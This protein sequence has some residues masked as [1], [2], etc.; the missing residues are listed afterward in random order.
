[1][2]N[3]KKTLMMISLSLFSIALISIG[4]YALWNTG[5]DLLTGFNT[6]QSGQVKMS[7]TETN[8]INMNNA[9][10]MQDS[11]GKNLDSYFE[12][13]ISTYIKTRA[14]DNAKRKLKY[15]IMFENT[16]A[17]I[18]GKEIS[19]DVLSDEN[20]GY[21]N[22]INTFFPIRVYLT[23]VLDNG[24]EVAVVEPKNI[25]TPD[26]EFL[27]VTQE[28]VFSNN[29][30]QVDTKYRLRT[31]IDYDFNI[32]DTKTI[33]GNMESRTFKINVNTDDLKIEEPE[34]VPIIGVMTGNSGI[35]KITHEIDDTLQVDS[36]FATEYRYSGKTANNYVT[37]N[38]ELWRII[39][40]IP[41]DDGT[42]KVENRL[43][44]IKS[45]SIGNYYW[46]NCNADSN[47]M[48]SNGKYLSDWTGSTL[49]TYL[50]ND[51][52]NTLST[53]AKNM[54][55]TTKYYL[56]G[57]DADV[58]SD[59]MWQYERKKTGTVYK[60]NAISY[61]GKIGLMNASDYGYSR[62]KQCHFMYYTAYDTPN[63]CIPKNWLILNQYEWTITQTKITSDYTFGG[64]TIIE[65]L[66]NGELFMFN[67]DN[68]NTKKYAV[69]PVLS[70]SSNVKISSGTGTNSDPYK[71]SI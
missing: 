38:N 10:P 25:L 18:S 61:V 46:N 31:W 26:D 29:K 44:I 2:K 47:G 22:S 7:Y 36:K 40:V 49:N 70:L 11:E 64:T 33:F 19:K 42:G 30:G 58:S 32:E 15:N 1:M 12:F 6:I 21:L 59:E 24:T 41:T 17:T 20:S 45:T 52:Y 69:R 55:G 66:N 23:K 63:I 9:L 50:N 62:I 5:N 37:F 48:C 16:K 57:Y 14:N 65:I 68:V 51:Y 34:Q 56:G 8:E 4:T 27:I 53:E 39:G 60:T 13:T 67:S 54:I 43:K 28:E 35:E 71:L 3:K